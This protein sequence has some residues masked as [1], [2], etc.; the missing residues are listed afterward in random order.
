MATPRIS[1]RA[2]DPGHRTPGGS[3]MARAAVLAAIACGLWPTA[4]VLAASPAIV[5]GTM[6]AAAIDRG[7]G[8]EVLSVHRLP[9]PVP[10]ADE[11]LIA[12]GATGIGPWEADAREHPGDGAKFPLVLGADGAGTVVAAGP[13]V[14]DFRPG[15]A[16]YGVGHGFYAEYA[17]AK[18][19]NISRIPRGLDMG[20]AALLAISGLSA[21]QGIDDVLQVKKGET[22]LIHGATGGVGTLAIQFARLRGARIMATAA[23]E[24]GM[25]LAR[26][27]GADVVVN[28]RSGDV[29][30]EAKRF[31]PAG[32]D[33]VLAF[34]GGQSLEKCVAALRQ[35]G[36]GRV[37]YLYGIDHLPVAT[38]GVRSTVYSFTSG[39]DEFRRLDDAMVASRAVVPIAAEYPLA[40]AAEAHRRLAGGGLLG[41][42]LLRVR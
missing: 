32:V 42:I 9:V 11:V 5:P 16:V 30:A 19:G 39:P 31:A 27:L 29:A 35:D 7:G 33:A 15:D 24:E 12:V 1:R 21:L 23:S 18:A 37:A 8:P 17:I 34:A 20:Q 13:L 10:G 14:R 40:Q 3:V 26:R 25:A 6:D 38:F 4:D 41:K 22:L 36:R 28:G 2:G